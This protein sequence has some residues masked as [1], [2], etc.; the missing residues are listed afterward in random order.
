MD[1]RDN[2]ERIG[3]EAGVPLTRI[4]QIIAGTELRVMDDAG[5]FIEPLPQGF[6]HF[7]E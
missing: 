6:D 1:Q 4:G 3:L 7:R 2:F 5:Q